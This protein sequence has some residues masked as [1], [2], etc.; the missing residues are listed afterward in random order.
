VSAVDRTTPPVSGP[1]RD[2]DFPPVD[3]RALSNG[4]DLRVA[5]MARLP[6]VSLRLFVR[7]GEAALSGSNAGLCVLTGAAL[8]GGTE[9]RSGSEMARALESI[10]ARLN[11]GAGWEGTSLALSCLAER[12][13]E[14]LGIVAETM[15][16]PAFPEHEV[17][18]ARAQ[19]VAGIRQRAK[20]P[21][22]LASDAALTRY[23]ASD[24]PYARPVDG[25]ADGIE[26]LGR[27]HL[28]GYADAS[29][30][31][32]SGGLIV[33]GDVD[34][35]EVSAMAEEHL[36]HW[37]GSPAPVPDFDVGPA[38]RQRRI[39]IVDRPGSV[40]SEV[41][42]GHVGVARDVPEY[43]ALS[44]ANMILGGM[45][46]SRLNLNL[47]EK[48]GFTYGVRSRFTYRSRPGIFQVSTAVG[49][50]VTAGA[51]REI[52]SELGRLVD[53]GPSSE[54]VEAARDYAAGIFGLHLETAGDVAT[55]IAQLVVYGL[56]D[57]YFHRYRDAVRA[58]TPE[59]AAE[60]ARSHIRPLDAQVVLVGDAES[61]RA[62]L[63][64]LDLGP[65]LVVPAAS[66]A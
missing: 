27:D 14:A 64:A 57:G 51:V 56:P 11:V 45:F 35:D 1:L 4:L 22:S 3:R 30:R 60:A 29:Y 41:R 59:A 13:P 36:G 21:A 39:V 8:E 18:R 24:V 20:D 10:G 65:V 62:P 17:E 50:D 33:V 9:H 7:G 28:V 47:R 44:V 32:R 25:F 31:P 66:P 54:E 43:F 37:V 16:E 38:T 23:F 46:T 52:L 42:V 63:E 40:Q 2:F 58:V 12:M 49:N 26:A 34:T 61:I 19:H 5:R 53:E 15:L 55:R 6:V 48:N